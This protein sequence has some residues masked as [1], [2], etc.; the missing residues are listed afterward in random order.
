MIATALNTL[1]GLKPKETQQVI[2]AGV[3][4]QTKSTWAVEPMAARAGLGIAK[5]GQVVEEPAESSLLEVN[6]RL[7]YEKQGKHVI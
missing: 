2:D 5:V 3:A 6:Q 7:R 1:L 4:R